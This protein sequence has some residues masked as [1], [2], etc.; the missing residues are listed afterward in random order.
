MSRNITDQ[1][2]SI[3]STLKDTE[4]DKNNNK[5][6]NNNIDKNNSYN[7]NNKTNSKKSEFTIKSLTLVYISFFHLFIL[8]KKY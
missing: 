6:K 2:L 5:N 1:F 8:V 3:I 4:I 7:S